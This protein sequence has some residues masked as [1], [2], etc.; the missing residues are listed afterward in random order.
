MPRIAAA[1]MMGASLFECWTLGQCWL[2]RW[3]AVAAAVLDRA[4]FATAE[5]ARTLLR[6]RTGHQSEYD[7]ISY[8]P[9]LRDKP[10]I[11]ELLTHS[12]A[13]AILDHALGWNEI[14]Y[15]HGQIA[16]RQARNTDKPY[17]PTPNID[18]IGSGRNGLAPGSEISNFTALVGV[19]LTTVDT[20]FAGNFTI[21]PGSHN[22][23][24]AYFAIAGEALCKKGC[25]GSG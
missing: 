13:K 24:E 8:C 15:D 2:A 3:S 20:E 11:S 14:E 5:S 19:F 9:D 23:L 12:P 4:A 1:S 7:N 18:G 25:P 22:R 21:W 17:P 10:P 16:I 6:S